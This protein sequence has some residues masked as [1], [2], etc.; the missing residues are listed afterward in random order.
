MGVVGEAEEVARVAEHINKKGKLNNQEETMG[1][2]LF[3]RKYSQIHRMWSRGKI[4]M[5]LYGAL[6]LIC[7]VLDKKIEEVIGNYYKIPLGIILIMFVTGYCIYKMQYRR[8][9]KRLES[10]MRKVIYKEYRLEVIGLFVYIMGSVGLGLR[11]ITDDKRFWSISYIVLV[12]NVVI[13]IIQ[14]IKSKK[15]LKEI[16]ERGLEF[17]DVTKFTVKYIVEESIGDRDDKIELDVSELKECCIRQT[18][19][20]AIIVRNKKTLEQ[21]D[22]I[23][24]SKEK[25]IYVWINNTRLKFNHGVG[26]MDWEVG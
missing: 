24:Y 13:Y 8:E 21:I 19:Y 15:I 6:M 22:S 20:G 11:L 23:E 5:L 10:M 26:K 18:A 12:I 3:S 16:K 2:V 25:P 7:I 14:Y 9:Y 4:D 1:R 17:E